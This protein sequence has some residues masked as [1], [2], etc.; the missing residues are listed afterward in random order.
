MNE[1]YGSTHNHT[2][3]S[4]YRLRDSTN[5]LNELCW[6]AAELGHNFIAITD[7]ETVSTAIDCQ[8]VEKSIREK[9]PNFKIIRGNEIYLCRNGLNKDNFVKGEDRFYHWI[10]LAKDEIGHQQ[11]RE[12]STRAWLRSFKMGRQI[13]VP[14]YY[15]DL[16][17]IV[18]NNPGHVIMQQ[19]CLGGKLSQLEVSYIKEP[20]KEKWEYIKQWVFHIQKICGKENFFLEVQPARSRDQLAVYQAT[21]KLQEETKIPVVISLDAHYLKKEDK[22]IHHAFLTAQDGD[23]ETEEFYA[24]T[25]MMSREE[26][27]SIMDKAIGEEKV[28][29]WMNN[30][31][32][33]YD[34]CE[35]YDL[36]KPT[37]IVYLPKTVD[38]ITDLQFLEY[39]DKIKELEYFYK[40]PHKENVDLAAA[41][42]TKILSD[43]EQYD[44]KLTYAA[45][46]DN[47]KAV[48]LA[49]EKMNTQ[50]SAY[51][52]NMRDYIKIIWEKGNS[53]VGCSRG[54]GLGFILLNILDI[55]QINPL[56]EK[57]KT[58]SF[59]FL[60]P[61]RVSPLDIDCD[62]EGGKRPQVYRALQEAYGEDRVSKV[63]TI[64]TEK[65]KSAILTA[66]RGLKIDPDEANYLSS[67]IKSERGI[68]FTLEQTYYG[69]EENGLK[70]DMKFKELM[71]GKYNNV[72][73]VA[74]KISGLCCGCGSHAGGVIFYDSPITETT[75]LMKT[76][77]GDVITQ[78]DLHKLESV[79]L[80]K[81]DLLSIEALDR[82]RACI[83]LLTN[84]N[85][86]NKN[87]S[88]RE[89]YESAVG[90]YNIDRTSPE[91]WKMVHEHK[92]QNLFQMEQ[93]SGIKGI[94]AV[95]PETVDELAALNAVIRL[96]PPEG[97]KEIPV[98]KFSRFKNNIEEWYNE[99]RQW[100]VDKKYWPVLEKI[101]GITY[102][103]CVQQEQFMMLVQQ[104]ELG[105]FSLLWSDKLRKS[106]AKKNPKAFETLEKEFFEVTKEKQCDFNLC[107]Y[108][109]KVLIA[110]N[111]GYGFNAAHT[112]GYSI[113]GLQE[114]NLA[115]KYPIIFW[116]TAN[117]IVDSGS[118][119]LED[120]IVLDN[121][122]NSDEENDDTIKN[123][124]CDYGRIATAIGK[125]KKAGISFTLPDI[126]TSGITYTPDV[127]NNVIISG[128]RGISRIGNQLIKDICLNRN[129]SSIEDFLNKVKVNKVQMI[130]LIKA[131]CFDNLYKESSREEIMEKY[132][133]SIADKKKRITL[134]NMQMLISKNM[135]PDCLNKQ[136]KVFNFN[137]YLK[138]NKQDGY[139]ILDNISFGFY[140][141]NYDSDNLIDVVIDEESKSAKIEQKVWDNIYKK[142]MD[143]VRSWMKENQQEI[144]N[145]LNKELWNETAEKYTEGNIS[146]WEMDSLS[147]Y[148]HN[149]E[150]SNLKTSVYEI[151]D[152]FKLDKEPKVER[153]YYTKKKDKIQLYKIYRIAGTVIDKDKKKNSVTI[154]TTSGVVTVKVWKNQF[155][156]WDKQLSQLGEDGKKHVLEKSWFTRGTKLI[157]TGIRRGDS[158]VLKKYK[159]TEWP[160]FEKINKLS[161]N[162]FILDS[163]TERIEIEED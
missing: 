161:E 125:M 86:L 14:T 80:L 110:A 163:S 30:T 124:S 77:N 9:Y 82:M 39:K 112:L 63:L 58:Y 12:I 53:L 101:V 27:H 51:L 5:S 13:R 52:L 69:D 105:G 139:Y 68:D 20:T 152:Y 155:S 22:E 141:D 66:C 11:I 123:S 109:W 75:A 10:L 148:Y 108:V 160:L 62:I 74:Q 159:N 137:K 24:T 117:L 107:N 19:S 128:L 46:D 127:E 61:E 16:I 136:V 23:R 81:I 32:K 111:K 31:K 29:E 4:N 6:Y 99:L 104:P 38:T 119:N 140:N 100:K 56:R 42:V 40:S 3:R 48:R 146:K 55:T 33:I 156:D 67:F 73:K 157:I 49:S 44:N 116:N 102:G 133:D 54:S 65:P 103:M 106:V 76:A 34:M 92:I 15:S 64:R 79:S 94:E 91:M 131:G 50:W 143:S 83:D 36:T 41:I 122:D 57:T 90:V 25:Y 1:F 60:N 84:Y 18:G 113:V 59:R 145:S 130:N 96:M 85:Y 21:L 98:E 35:D 151:S 132:I 26:I 147:F 154:L 87:L 135:I 138:K 153:E 129:Y 95:K 43:K 47:L 144:L 115:Y 45:I 2:D 17:D 97:S 142:E 8:D 37:R 28:S 118:M 162:G 88:L 7:H 158:F 120:E 71:D 126:N 78:Y 150:L 93:D 114:M 89:R 121:I 72:W 149:H 70:P 134:Q